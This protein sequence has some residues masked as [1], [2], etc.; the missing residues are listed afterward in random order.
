MLFRSWLS[1]LRSYNV[2]EG[3]QQFFAR[4]AAWGYKKL[5][6][7]EASMAELKHDTILYAEQSGAEMGDGG[8]EWVAGPFSQPFARGYV[9]PEPKLYRALAESARKI[10]EFLT[11]MF[12]DEHEYYRGKFSQFSEEMET[13]AGIADRALEDAMTPSDFLTIIELRLPSVLPEDIYDVY[14]KASQNQ[15]RMALVADVATDASAGR[16]LFMGVGAPRRLSVYVNDRSGG[17]RV[18][19]GYM[20][21]YYSFIQSLSEGRMNDDQWK[22]IVY[23][24]KR[25]DDMKQYLPAWHGKLYE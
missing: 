25:Q 16:A 10:L 17:F 24:T 13:L 22:A 4:T 23:D 21:S 18:T 15:L 6:T 1:A 5:T 11:P 12:P 14:D 3:S 19:E 2:S 20:F 9:E 8:G 7:A